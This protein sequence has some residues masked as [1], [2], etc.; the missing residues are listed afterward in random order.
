MGTST[1]HTSGP[2]DTLDQGRW[3]GLKNYDQIRKNVGLPVGA[4]VEALQGIA[5]IVLRADLSGPMNCIEAVT[6]IGIV[7]NAALPAV[8]SAAESPVSLAGVE[9]L[10]VVATVLAVAAVAGSES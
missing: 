10:A 8:D 1:D 6:Q 2:W 4:L 3:L 9:G 5:K 7:A